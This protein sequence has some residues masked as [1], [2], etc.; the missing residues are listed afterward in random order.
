MNP[1]FHF[2]C[3]CLGKCSYIIETH[4]HP[5]KVSR[6]C[7]L[8]CICWEKFYVIVQMSLC[9]AGEFIYYVRTI[10]FFIGVMPV[11]YV[12]HINVNILKEWISTS[13]LGWLYRLRVKQ[14]NMRIYD[15]CSTC[16]HNDLE[17]CNQCNELRTYFLCNVKLSN[18]LALPT[19]RGI[20]IVNFNMCIL[21][22]YD[23]SGC[24]YMKN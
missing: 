17:T 2:V 18:I 8:K 24:M 7:S 4:F 6:V 14:K 16:S 3:T 23:N 20:C 12:Q 10:F 11:S 9:F 13:S 21:K 1:L 22:L 19:L 15:H 5:W